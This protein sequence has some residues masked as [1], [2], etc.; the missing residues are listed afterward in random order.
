MSRVLHRIRALPTPI[1]TAAPARCSRRWSAASP[2]TGACSMGG[3][4]RRPSGAGAVLV[5][6]AAAERGPLE[7]PFSTDGGVTWE[8]NWDERPDPARPVKVRQR[9]PRPVGG[10]AGR[11]CAA[12]MWLRHAGEKKTATS[13]HSGPLPYVRELRSRETVY[14]SCWLQPMS[15]V[16]REL[17]RPVRLPSSPSSSSGNASRS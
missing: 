5:D 12:V 6:Q 1:D 13:A 8:T 17:A 2:A 7:Q 14:D 9:S 10:C 11:C 3:Q 16:P 4:R 15:V